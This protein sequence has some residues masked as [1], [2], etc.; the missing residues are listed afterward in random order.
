MTVQAP[1]LTAIGA[2]LSL[3]ASCGAGSGCDCPTACELSVA[4]DLNLRLPFRSGESCLVTQSYCGGE[5]WGHSGYQVDLKMPEGTPVLAIAGGVVH[6]VGTDPA[7]GNYVWL[8]HDGLQHTWYSYYGHLHHALVATIGAPVIQGQPIGLSGTT[9]ITSGPHLHLQVKQGAIDATGLGARPVPM[10]F[11][12]VSDFD[13]C[14]EAVA[15]GAPIF[16]PLQQV[17]A[18]GLLGSTL[19]V[20]ADGC[21]AVVASVSEGAM[22]TVVGGPM[23]CALPPA[24]PTCGQL[25]HYRMWKVDW[26]GGIVG[27][28]A[29]NWLVEMSDATVILQPGP[30]GKDTFFGL[31]YF[32]GGAPDYDALYYGGW[33]DA[34]YDY[35]E[36]DLSGAPSADAT[37]SATLSFYAATAGDPAIQLW[38]I[39]SPWTEA[40]VS[41]AQNPSS[42]YYKEFG[43]I[44]PPNGWKSVDVT[45]IYK[46]WQSGQFPNYG[47]KLVPQATVAT[48]GQFR[49][50]DAA[51][52]TVRPR[53]TIVTV[54]PATL[55]DMNGDRQVDGADLGILLGSWGQCANCA[56]DLNHDG[57]VDGTDLGVLLGAW[58]S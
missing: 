2:V 48:N 12:G 18:S 42:A 31:V 37:V 24:S 7:G 49:S 55:G 13:S 43:P 16:V 10:T 28:S 33:G 17:R 8:K 56:A 23:Q 9:G 30:E 53:L 27:W 52:P 39:T 14:L 45:E 51:D 47:L 34:Y 4:G 54:S 20:R 21:G 58:S 25:P 19:S 40:G 26:G 6:L 57:A 46:K 29:Q 38:R 50:S 11:D 3:A 1:M 32:Q 15:Q 5:G 44:L 36:F 41:L 35:I 22:G